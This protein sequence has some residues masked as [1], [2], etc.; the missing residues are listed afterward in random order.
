VEDPFRENGR[1]LSAQPD[2]AS[3]QE[4]ND[5]DMMSREEIEK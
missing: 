4:I 3:V 1:V 2:D 5:E